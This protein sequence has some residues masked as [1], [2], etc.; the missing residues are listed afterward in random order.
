MST[1]FEKSHCSACSED[2][3]WRMIWQN[4]ALG[5]TCTKIAENLCVDKSTVSRTLTS[6]NSTGSVSKKPYPEGR[7]FQKLIPPAQ[8]LFLQLCLS[9]PRIYLREIQ[10]ELSSVIDI[11]ISESAICKFLHKSGFTYQWLHYNNM[12]LWD[13]SSHQKSL[14]TPLIWNVYIYWQDR[15]WL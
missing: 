13:S 2:L 3:R 15:Y 5:Y 10:D 6:F 1:L 9:K 14:Y 8:L 4:K 7:A 11:E 12:Y